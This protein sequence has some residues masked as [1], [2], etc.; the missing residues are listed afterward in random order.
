MEHVSLG[1]NTK[2][3]VA[4]V[5]LPNSL[6]ESYW[7]VLSPPWHTLPVAGTGVV[8]SSSRE[9]VFTPSTE[10]ASYGGSVPGMLRAVKMGSNNIWAKHEVMLCYTSLVEW[11]WP[12][13]QVPQ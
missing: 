2:G 6:A 3:E 10:G 12:H 9:T 7:Q 11:E 13:L 1:S 4:G 8:G 5:L